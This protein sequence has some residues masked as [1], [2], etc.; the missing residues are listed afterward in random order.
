M[1]RRTLAA[2]A[3]LALTIVVAPGSVAATTQPSAAGNMGG[4]TA[5]AAQSPDDPST[6]G[7]FTLQG[8]SAATYRLPDDVEQVWSTRYP[9]GTKQTRYQQVVDGADVLGGQV[10]VL[11]NAGGIT[12]VVGAYFGTLEPANALRLSAADSLK[13]AA[14]ILGAGGERSTKL[15][16]DPRDGALFY[17]V[18][19]PA[20]RTATDSLRRRRDGRDPQSL[21]RVGRW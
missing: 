21:R 11:R 9:D 16:I 18:E 4:T 8:D 13:V 19:T 2:A 12:S 17:E 6:E 14:D 3:A 10:T 7:S 5:V 15:H 1:T 20:F